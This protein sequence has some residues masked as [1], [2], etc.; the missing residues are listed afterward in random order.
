MSNK[1]RLRLFTWECDSTGQR[2]VVPVCPDHDGGRVR[3]RRFGTGTI[4]ICEIGPHLIGLCD[5]EAFEKEI[6]EARE[7]LVLR[8]RVSA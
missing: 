4:V 2:E 6:E 8:K 1:C 5:C 7:K 3:F